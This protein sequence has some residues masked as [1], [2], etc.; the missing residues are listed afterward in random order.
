MNLI[1]EMRKGIRKA[2]PR[3]I[4]AALPDIRGLLQEREYRKMEKLGGKLGIP[5]PGMHCRRQIFMDGEET[6]DSGLNRSHTVNRNYYNMA[7]TYANWKSLDDATFGT[8]LLSLKATDASIVRNTGG[9]IL[10]PA[11]TEVVDLEA[12]NAVGGG[13]LAPSGSILNGIVFG[14]SSAAESFEG[15]VLG[16]PI[17]N[18]SAAGEMDYS[19]SELHSITNATLTL[20]NTL[21]R[22]ANNNSGGSITVEEAALYTNIEWQ[23]PTADEQ[24]MITR[25]LT[26]GDVCANTAQYRYTYEITLVYPS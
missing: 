21:I 4:R 17:V 24:I 9:Y 26:G 13:L 10:I 15:F 12:R 2:D 5:V 6:F 25:D 22:D 1:N 19:Q 8:G 23:A 7:F 3:L 16:T 20:K 14:T 18:G 11:G